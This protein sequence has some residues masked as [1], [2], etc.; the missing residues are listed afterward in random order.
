MY[1]KPPILTGHS[2]GGALS[3][4]IATAVV[5]DTG[6]RLNEVVTFNSPGIS[7]TA[8]DAAE[9]TIRPRVENGVTHY[10]VSGDFVSLAGEKYIPGDVFLT[11]VVNGLLFDLNDLNPLPGFLN[12]SPQFVTLPRHTRPILIEQ[13][14]NQ[15][16]QITHQ[17]DIL[18]TVP[19]AIDRLNFPEFNFLSDPVYRDGLTKGL[20]VLLGEEIH[21][22]SFFAPKGGG[23]AKAT[24][25]F[26]ISVWN[27]C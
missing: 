11:T 22:S 21:I 24:T 15:D 20:Y 14:E 13:V 8:V 5:T 6:L 2:L 1:D 25:R 27:R 10:I 17:L 9:G 23:V 7:R 4:W 12:S 3:Q 16:G 26:R 19:L 18:E